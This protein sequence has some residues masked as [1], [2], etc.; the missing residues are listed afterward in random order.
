MVISWFKKL[1]SMTVFQ[2]PWSW[3]ISSSSP[4]PSGSSWRGF[5]LG[6]SLVD[7]LLFQILY[8]VESVV[9]VFAF[10]FFFLCCGCNI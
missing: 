4:S 6:F 3:S 5:H 7:D 10:C 2:W 1:N 9:L 8:C